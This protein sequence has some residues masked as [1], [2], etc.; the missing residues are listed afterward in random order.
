MNRIIKS[1]PK[2]YALFLPESFVDAVL[3]KESLNVDNIVAKMKFHQE[4]MKQQ[5]EGLEQAQKTKAKR[6]EELQSTN[7]RF[8]IGPTQ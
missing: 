3:T 6:G 1:V 7:L 8:L 4:L 5:R 2:G